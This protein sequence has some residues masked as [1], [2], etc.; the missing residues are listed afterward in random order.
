MSRG[1]P[2]CWE[3]MSPSLE[4][5]GTHNPLVI[6]FGPDPALSRMLPEHKVI[7]VGLDNAGKTTILYQ[8]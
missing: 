1:P 8:L 4:A 7:V 6:G 5:G 2:A 3:H